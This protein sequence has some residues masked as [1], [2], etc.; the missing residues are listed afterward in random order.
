MGITPAS[1]LLRFNRG[2]YDRDRSVLWVNRGF[3]VA[4]VPARMG[5]PPE[6]T[7]I[8]LVAG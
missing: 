7:K 3:G 2:R 5:V 1:A 8:V 6:V 4:A